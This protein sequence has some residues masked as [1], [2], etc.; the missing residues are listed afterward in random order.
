MH[1]GVPPTPPPHNPSRRRGWIAFIVVLLLAAGAALAGWWFAVGRFQPTPNVVDLSQ[2]AAQERVE[3]AGLS[4]KIEQTAFS[5]TIDPGHVISTEPGP[6]DDVL[7]DGTVA[8]VVSKGPERH[9]VPKLDGTSESEA[10]DAI[11]EASLTVGKTTREW[12]EK[13]AVGKV[14]SY[15]PKA[16]TAL[17]RDAEVRLVVSKG[18]KPIKISDH[19][20]ESADAAASALEA[21][22]FEVK[23]KGRYSEVVDEG[24]VIA[25]RPGKGIGHKGDVI[26]LV[27][28]KGPPLAEVPNVKGSGVQAATEKLEDAGFKVEI[29][30]ADL[31]IGLGY[32]VSQNPAAGTQAPIGSTITLSKV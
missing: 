23:R 30:E 25:Q 4:F 26:T 6:G 27:V 5:E 19:E 22:G 24:D 2:A 9:D 3:D 31:Y 20:G 13:F 10:I 7:K 15:T 1:D 8:A 14:I 17:R 29:V 21:A 11:N 28:S 16:G 12:S 18:P 32:I